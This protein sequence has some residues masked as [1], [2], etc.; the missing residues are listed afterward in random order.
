[1][2][3]NKSFWAAGGLLVLIILAKLFSFA[4]YDAEDD[5]FQ[6]YFRQHY[7][8]F[9]LNIPK[10]LN[11]AGEKVPIQDFDVRERLD[12]ELIVN[13]YWQ[14]QTLLVLK[15]A[16]RWFPVIVPILKKHGI[17]EDFKYLALVESGFLHA[18]S[19]AGA[20]GYWQLVEPTAKQ[21]GLEITDEVDERYHVEKSTEAACKYFKESYRKYND[22]TLVAA[23]YNMGISG[24]SRQLERQKVNNYYDLLL[25]E[26][27]AR[28]VFRAIAMKEIITNPKNYGYNF[29]KKDLYPPFSFY[30][31]K[32]DTT[33]GNLAEFAIANKTSYKV[34]KLLN[35][36]LRQN[37][38]T[39]TSGKS[40]EIKLPKPGLNDMYNHIADQPVNKINEAG[41]QNGDSI[42]QQPE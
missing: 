18:V 30:T 41:T 42:K 12:R 37:N 14:S 38:L 11:F 8:I 1:M 2:N 24:I 26:E 32:A 19:P 34:L 4:S 20:T 5:L 25:N 22:W 15:R 39:V 40:Y 13:T 6:K 28:Y 33:I 7:K 23:S 21:Y 35:P 31:V 36:W 29:R 10:D 17:P 27:T 16:N 3:W 9:T